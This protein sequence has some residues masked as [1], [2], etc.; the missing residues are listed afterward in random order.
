M[1]LSKPWYP[2]LFKW[3]IQSLCQ[4]SSYSEILLIH[5]QLS[6]LGIGDFNL[7]NPNR[8]FTALTIVSI[9]LSI[10]ISSVL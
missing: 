5:F 6:T 10:A 1:Y 8:P 7:Y 9:I 2:T 4:S 3:Q